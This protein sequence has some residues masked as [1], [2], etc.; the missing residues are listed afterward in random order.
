[1]IKKHTPYFLLIL[2]VVSLDLISKLWALNVL[3]YQEDVSIIG[4]RLTFYL[5][6]N[7]EYL[8]GQT[9]TVLQNAEPIQATLQIS[10]VILLLG[11]Y[12][13]GL[14]RFRIKPGFKWIGGMAIFLGSAWFLDAIN[15]FNQS[16][17]DI[18]MATLLAKISVSTLM[19]IVFFK[20]QIP[21]LKWALAFI[22]ATG[23]GNGLSYFY[24]PYKVVDFIYVEGSYELFRI[25]IFNI[26]DVSYDIGML[27]ILG[28]AV[29]SITK[30]IKQSVLKIKRRIINT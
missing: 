22:I 17:V 9:L 4:Q 25:G 13:I 24:A 19:M 29:V 14:D 28:Y 12:I 8:S 18:R 6:Y 21:V 26:A 23:I 11:L 5:T 3:P 16:G 10:V 20:V 1:M 7:E 2:A 30:N 27:M 15:A